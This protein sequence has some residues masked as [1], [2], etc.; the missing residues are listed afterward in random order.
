MSED[1]TVHWE[2]AN[3][4]LRRSRPPSAVSVGREGAIWS[5]DAGRF[6]LKVLSRGAESA[7]QQ[8]RL[9]T[10]L[11]ALRL[12][13]PQPAGW[14][15]D[16]GGNGVLAMRSAG[17][18][19]EQA[20][21]GLLAELGA[22]LAGIHQA[23]LSPLR[24]YLRQQDLRPYLDGLFRGVQAHPDIAHTLALLQHRISWRPDHLVHG[25]FHLGNICVAGEVL[26]VVDWTDAGVGDARYDLAWAVALLVIYTGK[27]AAGEFRQAYANR[28]GRPGEDLLS[29]EA[30]AILRWLLLYRTAPV[31][32]EREKADAAYAFLDERLRPEERQHLRPLYQ[33]GR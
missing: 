14:G 17:E 7:Q 16:S 12:P 8:F 5:A 6:V 4:E 33:V 2:E 26:T 21:P 19:L 11:A 13:V 3:A 30:L 32:V 1:L 9:L 10:A 22:I 28:L 29:F 15:V 31:P 24:P 23:D 18:P 27:D 25:D 20:T